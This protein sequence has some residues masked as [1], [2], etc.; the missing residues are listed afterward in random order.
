MKRKVG[1]RGSFPNQRSGFRLENLVISG[2][3]LIKSEI[4]RFWILENRCSIAGKMRLTP[5][6]REL[7]KRSPPSGIIINLKAGRGGTETLDSPRNFP[8]I[9][10]YPL[11]PSPLHETTVWSPR[12]LH[13]INQ[14][15]CAKYFGRVPSAFFSPSRGWKI[16]ENEG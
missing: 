2:L 13:L 16:R 4:S 12:F 9:F 3:E 11:S 14:S 8:T 5:V 10:D 7:R 6:E 15:E 1:S